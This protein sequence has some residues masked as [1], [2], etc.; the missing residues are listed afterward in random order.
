MP[1]QIWFFFNV[2]SQ[3][4]YLRLQDVNDPFLK[5]I[6]SSGPSSQTACTLV[7]CII[8]P[9]LEEVVYRGF[10]MTSLVS[11]MKWQ[12]AVAISSII[13]SAAHFSGENFLQLLII[14]LVLGCSYCWTGNLSSSI[15]IHSLYNALILFSTF[16]SW[17]H[18][19]NHDLFLFSVYYAILL[20][21]GIKV[22]L[23]FL[24]CN[25]VYTLVPAYIVVEVVGAEE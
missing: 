3:F 17:M 13:F 16:I 12:Q 23:L 7:Y 1:Y 25:N 15:A 8:T 22:S 10:L 2:Q 6:L 18:F 21:T 11:K 5:Q 24:H 14:G 19:F 20:Q 4:C 9:L